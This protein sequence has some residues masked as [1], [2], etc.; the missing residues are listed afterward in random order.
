MANLSRKEL[1]QEW[2]ESCSFLSEFLGEEIRVA[3]V[4]N[5]YYSRAVGEAAASAGIEVLFNSEPATTTRV[6]DGCLLVGR[7]SIKAGDSDQLTGL[8]AS[9]QS[10]RG[11]QALL[12]NSR[13]A[14]KLLGGPA[15]LRLRS[16]WLARV[17]ASRAD[18]KAHKP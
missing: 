14:A 8:L 11:R 15:Y 7:Y 4:P 1:T 16:M 10:C 5:G 3:S 13:K 17:E 6:V 2:T 18:S 12:W 9:R